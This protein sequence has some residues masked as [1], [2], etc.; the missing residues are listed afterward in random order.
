MSDRSTQQIE[1]TTPA[2]GAGAEGPSVEFFAVGLAINLVLIVAF[3]VWAFK[4]GKK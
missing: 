1:E 3:F 4:Q 2:P